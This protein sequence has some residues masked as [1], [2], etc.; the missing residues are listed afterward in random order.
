MLTGKAKEDFL[1]N[2]LILNDK[3]RSK[4]KSTRSD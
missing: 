4:N 3:R 1:N 2:K